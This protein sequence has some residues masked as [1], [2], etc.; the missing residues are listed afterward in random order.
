[1]KNILFLL[2]ISVIFFNLTS[3]NLD[4]ERDDRKKVEEFKLKI[5]ELKELQMILVLLNSN[6]ANTYHNDDLYYHNYY[7]YDWHNVSTYNK[8]YN[9]YQ[10]RY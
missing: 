5:E 2:F 8:N 4:K 10:Y 6:S 7:Y 9:Y 3:C 1:M